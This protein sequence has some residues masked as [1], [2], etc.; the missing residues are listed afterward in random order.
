M[1][2]FYFL[3]IF[4]C[5]FNFV[6]I[7]NTRFDF[8]VFLT[9]QLLKVAFS[10]VQS[11]SFSSLHFSKLY[12]IWTSIE[13]VFIMRLIKTLIIKMKNPHKLRVNFTTIYLFK[14]T[15]RINFNLSNLRF[16]KDSVIF[17]I[18]W[19]PNIFPIIFFSESFNIILVHMKFV[20]GL[21]Q[22]PKSI[23]IICC[24]HC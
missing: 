19:E 24:H 18:C 17:L 3:K 16:F 6:R 8:C 9:I 23:K 10:L 13:T 2:I 4:F 11:W 7:Y 5:I 21:A 20:R 14:Y 15:L 22:L 1:M 12:K